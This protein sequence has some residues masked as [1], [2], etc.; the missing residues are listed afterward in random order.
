M[1]R[2]HRWTEIKIAAAEPEEFYFL[3]HTL[4]VLKQSVNRLDLE[5]PFSDL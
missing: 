1:D 3:F 2:N 4:F 5:F